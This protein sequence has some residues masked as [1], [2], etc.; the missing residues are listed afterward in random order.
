[1]RTHVS[2]NVSDIAKSVE[3]YEKFFGVKPQKRTENYAKFDLQK[4]SLNFRCSLGER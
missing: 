3:F 4:P 1:M 2:I